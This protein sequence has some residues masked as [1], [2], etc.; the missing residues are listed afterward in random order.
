MAYASY[1]DYTGDYGGSRLGEEE[2]D[3]YALRAEGYLEVLTYGRCADQATPEV[4][5]AVTL[6]C[7]AVADELC[8]QERE[9]PLTAQS[10]GQWSRSYAQPRSSERCIADAARLYLRGTGLLWRGWKRA[11]TQD[12]G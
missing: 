4:T 12:A 10:V 1:S 3:R 11:V 9:P 6:A 5:R 8:R 2:F 7:C